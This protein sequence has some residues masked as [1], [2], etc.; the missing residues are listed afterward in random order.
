MKLNQDGTISITAEEAEKLS[1]FI[2]NTLHQAWD[3]YTDH[4]IVGD[5]YTWEQGMERMDPEMYKMMQEFEG[6]EWEAMEPL[7][8]NGVPAKL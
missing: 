1:G 6:I 3:R 5:K 8:P 4:Y 2:R 7:F